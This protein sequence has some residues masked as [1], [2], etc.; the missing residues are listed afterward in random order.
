MTFR[1]FCALYTYIVSQIMGQICSRKVT[2]ET[3]LVIYHLKDAEEMCSF[4]K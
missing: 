1:L 3:K 4:T 2:C